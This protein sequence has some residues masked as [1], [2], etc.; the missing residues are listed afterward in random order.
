[1][2]NVKVMLGSA[3]DCNDKLYALKQVS[4]KLTGMK[5]TLHLENYDGTLLLLFLRKKIRK[6]YCY[7][8][9]KL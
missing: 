6:S 9:T 7:F 3:A 4:E 8:A 5:G 2:G 1:M